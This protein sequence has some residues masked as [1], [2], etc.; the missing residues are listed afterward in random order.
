MD[1]LA[2]MT[3][4]ATVVEVGSF[5]GAAEVLGLPKARVSQRVSDLERALGVRLLQRTTRAL[6]LTEDGQAY[7]SKCQAI[8]QE[9]DELEGALKGG[10]VAPRGR[11]RVEALV[12][13]ARWVLAPQLHEFQA[14]YPGIQL[15]LGGTDR[16]SHLLAE[17]IDCAIRGG[18][19]ADSGQIARH[20]CDVRLGLYAAP[21]YLQ[22]A[23]A[24]QQPQDLA[25]HRRLSWLPGPRDP[26]AWPLEAGGEAFELTGAV[27]LPGT[28]GVQFDDPDAAIAACM[29]GGGIC[30]GAPFAVAHWVRAGALVPVLAHWSFAARPIHI[31]Y[32]SNKHLSA[33]VRCFV[34]WALEL[35]Q[36]S[37]SVRMTPW[38]LAQEGVI[39][40]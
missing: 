27:E 31:V 17:G 13:V 21:A 20:A 23:G 28:C 34:D 38:E 6:S 29:A 24:P 4:F 16:V 25:R 7:V 15:R 18:A 30:P 10:A 22:A 37:P 2:A 26:F 12:S 8:L 5:T 39:A 33:R 40:P 3:T 9:I 35:M 32:P 1:K 14:R 19:L 36:N 11:L